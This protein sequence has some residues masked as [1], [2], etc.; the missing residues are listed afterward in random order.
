[1]E[2]LV[3][4]SWLALR[5]MLKAEGDDNEWTHSFW[6]VRGYGDLNPTQSVAK[7]IEGGFWPPS[8]FFWILLELAF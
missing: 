6:I 3:G 8:L 2:G 5:V 7:K 4:R 1:M